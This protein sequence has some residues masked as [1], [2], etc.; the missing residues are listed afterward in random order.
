M[1]RR[2]V[3]DD[4]RSRI[5]GVSHCI[6]RR[7]KRGATERE[8]ERQMRTRSVCYS[9]NK[10]DLITEVKRQ[11]QNHRRCC[12]CCWRSVHRHLTTS[13][14]TEFASFPDV[15]SGSQ[16][17]QAHGARLDQRSS[18]RPTACPR[19]PVALSITTLSRCPHRH[20]SMRTTSREDSGLGDSN[21]WRTE[22]VVHLCPISP[23]PHP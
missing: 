13:G 14:Q 16:R 17:Q 11:R 18:A 2:L 15:I 12:C 10:P 4:D 21:R 19:P 20:S 5:R 6:G 22:E 8:R 7:R 23:S 1:V 9:N 3:D